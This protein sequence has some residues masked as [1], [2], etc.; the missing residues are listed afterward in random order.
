M[1]D[2]K[3]IRLE[4]KTTIEKKVDD[5]FCELLPVLRKHSCNIICSST[6]STLRLIFMET[7]LN[8]SIEP[9]SITFYIT[10]PDPEVGQGLNAPWTARYQISNPKQYTQ[11]S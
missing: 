7:E 5:F 3:V 2:G 11:K 4:Q 1:V 9:P 8:L 10:Y 6:E